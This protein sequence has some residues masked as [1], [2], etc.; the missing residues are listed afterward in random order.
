MSNSERKLGIVIL[1]YNSFKDTIKLLDNLKNQTLNQFTVLVIDNNSTNQSVDQ[2]SNY[3][4]INK[5]KYELELLTNSENLGYSYGN[6]VGLSRLKEENFEYALVLNNDIIIEDIFFLEKI[7]ISIDNDNSISLIGPGIIQHG[8]VE[9]PL[10]KKRPSFVSIC[11]EN[12]FLPIVIIKNKFERKLM[13]DKCK[14]VYS[15]SGCC[16]MVRLADFQNGVFDERVFL[17]GEERIL[18]E[19]MFKN[20][21]KC[22]FI[23]SLKVIHNHSKTVRKTYDKNAIIDMQIDSYNF[24]I[25]EYRSD[26]SEL[27]SKIINFSFIIYKKQL[28]FLNLIRRRK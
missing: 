12:I 27:K 25:S 6:N 11:L 20:E 28:L 13:N 16:F 4:K 23:P 7:L 19:K 5:T 21:K 1:N 3:L 18:G 14:I 2:L 8:N 22:K 17:Y 10:I 26:I 9:L 24:Y 15:V